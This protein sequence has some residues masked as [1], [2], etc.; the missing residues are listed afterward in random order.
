M[1]CFPEPN[2]VLVLDNTQI[3]HNGQ[4]A[5]IV[6]AKGALIQYLSP[7]SP[8]LNPIEKGFSLYKSN[9][10]QYKDLLMGGEEAYDVIDGFIPL[11]FTGE[12]TRELFQG[13]GYLVE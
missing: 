2:S 11:V 4:I 8:N 1:N 12:I 6:E 3:H 10:Q 7:Y 5:L 13:S 9:L